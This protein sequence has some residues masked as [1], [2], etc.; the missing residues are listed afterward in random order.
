MALFFIMLLQSFAA[1]PV[2]VFED[3]GGTSSGAGL[4]S[5][6]CLLIAGIVGVATRDSRGGGIT[7]AVFYAVSGTIGISS[8]GVYRELTV[9][10]LVSFVFAIVFVVG[11]VKM[12]KAQKPDVK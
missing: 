5:A 8:S 4:L 10:A 1:G 12:P 6:F 2:E 9:W 7:A 3:R 11:S